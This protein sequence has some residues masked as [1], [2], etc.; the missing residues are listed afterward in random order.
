MLTFNALSYSAGQAANLCFNP[1]VM[2]LLMT[3]VPLLTVEDVVSVL[4]QR[5]GSA[6]HVVGVD[7]FMGCWQD[8]A[9]V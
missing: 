8:S 1:N 3:A 5:A 7:G 4:H 6:C 9:C 2:S